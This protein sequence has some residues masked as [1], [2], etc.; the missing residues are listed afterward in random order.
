MLMMGLMEGMALGKPASEGVRTHSYQKEW[1][2][3]FTMF[4]ILTNLITNESTVSVTTCHIISVLINSFV[5]K[6]SQAVTKHFTHQVHRPDDHYGCRLDD[7]GEMMILERRVI[8]KWRSV[9]VAGPG[10][11]LGGTYCPVNIKK[12]ERYLGHPLATAIHLPNVT[13]MNFQCICPTGWFSRAWEGTQFLFGASQQWKTGLVMADAFI[14]VD[15][16]TMKSREGFQ[17]T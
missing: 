15:M 6:Q 1:P 2:F 12:L 4:K 10:L 13:V 7:R 14:A 11:W 5:S 9:A 17:E 3:F 16:T 8:C